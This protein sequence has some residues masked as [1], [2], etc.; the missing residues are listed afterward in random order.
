MLHLYRRHR[1]SCSHRSATYRR[2]QCPINVQGSLG[3][4]TIRESLNLNS[5]E[6]ASQLIADWTL[7][8]KIRPIGSDE[9]L[10][11]DGVRAFIDDRRTRGLQPATLAVH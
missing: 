10:I 11:A 5:W 6:A 7:A 3:N 2:C 4:E 1:T 8:G 9:K